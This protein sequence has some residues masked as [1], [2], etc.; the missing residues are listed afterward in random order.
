MK[1][2]IE[3][4][5]QIVELFNRNVGTLL[6]A[7]TGRGLAISV[8]ELLNNVA[9]QAWVSGKEAGKSEADEELEALRQTVA[10]L[11]Q[12]LELNRTASHSRLDSSQNVEDVDVKV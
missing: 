10:S 3:I 6:T 5:P 12:E 7:D 1:I 11:K 2:E 9:E 4:N 8:Q